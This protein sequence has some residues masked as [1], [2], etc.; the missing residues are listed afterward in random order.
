[1][2]GSLS[3]ID[4]SN[5]VLIRMTRG[6]K[7]TKILFRMAL[8]SSF[9]WAVWHDEALCSLW[10]V[11]PAWML[12][13]VIFVMVVNLGPKIKCIDAYYINA[14]MLWRDYHWL[15]WMNNAWTVFLFFY[16]NFLYWFWQYCSMRS[17]NLVLP[18][19]F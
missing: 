16:V 19:S 11:F 10:N 18:M 4:L 7:V 14:A 15:S 3:V 13:N 1:M 12:C 9:G 17:M 5:E 8:L 6:T 2:F